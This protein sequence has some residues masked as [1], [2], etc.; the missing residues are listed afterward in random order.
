MNYFKR[1]TDFCAGLAAFDAII[2]LL[3]K[4]MSF[5]PAEKPEG[6]KETL[7]LFFDEKSQ[8]S[9]R[10]YLILITLLLLSVVAGRIFERLPYI[11]FAVSLLPLMQICIMISESDLES[12]PAFILILGIIHSLGNVLHAFILDRKDGRRRALTCVNIF[13]I[14]LACLGLLVKKWAEKFLDM[15][16]QERR[17]LPPIEREFSL[18]VRNGDHEIIYKLAILF[19][20]TVLLSIILRDIYFV[21]AIASALPLGYT[22]YL[23]STEKL[24]LFPEL[25]FILALSYF[26]CR[27]L[28]LFIEPMA[29]TPHPVVRLTRKLIKR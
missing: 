9:A 24:I 18:A 6:L 13:G 20:V 28:V 7:K 16:K 15:T 1:F 2:F 11:S 21:D 22:L 5:K 26:L 10:A 4:Y 12:R 29:S 25:I 14:S 23:F 8:D 27:L 17:E 19:A 3:G